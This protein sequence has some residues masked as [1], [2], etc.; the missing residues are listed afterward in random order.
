MITRYPQGVSRDT[1]RMEVQAAR[2]D[3]R[4]TGKTGGYRSGRPA[5]YRFLQRWFCSGVGKRHIASGMVN[6]FLHNEFFRAVPD[7]KPGNLYQRECLPCMP[8]W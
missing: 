3:I 7:I 5:G 1:M 6:A 4:R 2:R 8:G